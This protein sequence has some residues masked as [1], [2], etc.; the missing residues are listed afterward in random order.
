MMAI[1]PHEDTHAE[2]DGEGEQRR[3][4]VPHPDRPD[5][6][7]QTPERHQ[8]GQDRDVGRHAIDSRER[9][10]RLH[11]P[12]PPAVEASPEDVVAGELVEE[13]DDLKRAE[14]GKE[15]GDAWAPVP[16]H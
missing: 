8:R 14:G 5:R 1:T 4:R 15:A 7:W 2:S 6:E 12:E 16:G 3:Q 11:E 9:A 10:D 13:V